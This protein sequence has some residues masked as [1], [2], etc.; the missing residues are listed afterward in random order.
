MRAASDN[1]YLLRAVGDVGVDMGLEGN[2]FAFGKC[3]IGTD[4]RHEEVA[5]QEVLITFDWH[6]QLDR[7][8]DRNAFAHKIVAELCHE[9]RADSEDVE[10][11]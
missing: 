6:H 5:C 4:S 7:L 3:V 10:R 2:A 11:L 8:F 1:G 9:V